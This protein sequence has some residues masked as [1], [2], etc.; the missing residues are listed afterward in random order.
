MDVLLDDDDADDSPDSFVNDDDVDIEVVNLIDVVVDDVVNDNVD[1]DVESYDVDDNSAVV[2]VDEFFKGDVDDDDYDDGNDSVVVNVTGG[3]KGFVL[4]NVDDDDGGNDH[5][6]DAWRNASMHTRARVDEI[7]IVE[8]AMK[9][10]M[11][12]DVSEDVNVDACRSRC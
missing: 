6:R 2:V 11:A 3:V 9:E 1:D 7:L 4:Q 8:D 5:C 12:K 10:V